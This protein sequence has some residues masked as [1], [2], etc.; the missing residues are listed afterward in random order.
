MSANIKKPEHFES[1]HNIKNNV[2]IRSMQYKRECLSYVCI[3]SK[4]KIIT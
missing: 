3:I 1:L 4:K 2:V